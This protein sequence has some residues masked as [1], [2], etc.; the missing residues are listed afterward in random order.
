MTPKRTA[1]TYITTID[2]PC[3]KT[4]NYWIMQGTA[5]LCQKE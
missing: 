2:L 5:L 4:E 1:L 3:E